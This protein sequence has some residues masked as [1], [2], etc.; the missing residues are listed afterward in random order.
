MNAAPVK[1]SVAMVTYNRAQLAVR[2]LES[3]FAQHRDD[4]EVVVVDNDSRDGTGELIAAKF[5]QVKLIRL[6]RNLGC[7][8]GRN[9]AYANCRG[10]FIVNLDDDGWMSDGALEQIE[11]V[12]ERDERIGVIALRQSFPEGGEH[13][14][15]A[16]SAEFKDVGVFAGGVSA[17]RHSMLRKI[18]AFPHDF[19]LFAEES[20]LAIR[21]LDAGYRIVSAPHIVMWHPYTGGSHVNTRHDYQLFRNNLLVTLRLYPGQLLLQ[22]FPARLA[23]YFVS[24]LRRG[25]LFKY[26]RAVANVMAALPGTLLHRQPATAAAVTKHLATRRDYIVFDSSQV[27]VA[28]PLAP[29]AEQA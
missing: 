21:A 23:S 13:S 19:F 5:P 11:S 25:S 18:G 26:L 1:F 15:C 17:L 20:F 14:G 27:T 16:M 9:Q 8:D 6:A 2:A 3:V 22:Y 4:C 29:A 28:A 7:P 10:E 24:A 12:F